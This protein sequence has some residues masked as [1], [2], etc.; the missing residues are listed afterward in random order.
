MK[1]QN[2]I[3]IIGFEPMTIGTATLAADEERVRSELCCTNN[4]IRVLCDTG[5]DT[6][7]YCKQATVYYNSCSVSIYALFLNRKSK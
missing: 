7:T 3:T 2:Q 4:D 5:I 6:S 1:D